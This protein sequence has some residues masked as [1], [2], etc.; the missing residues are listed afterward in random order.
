MPH[1]G[2]QGDKNTFFTDV[3]DFFIIILFWGVLFYINLNKIESKPEIYSPDI[4]LLCKSINLTAWYILID[5]IVL[6]ESH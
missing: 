6:R 3:T 4:L 5:V 2:D 1:S